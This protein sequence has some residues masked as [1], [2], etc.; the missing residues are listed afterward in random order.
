MN[1]PF[2]ELSLHD[3]EFGRWKEESSDIRHAA[4]EFHYNLVFIF[5]IVS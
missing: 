1:G 3:D 4:H 5:E 2:S